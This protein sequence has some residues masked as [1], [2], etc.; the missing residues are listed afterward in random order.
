MRLDPEQRRAVDADG[1]VAVVAGAGTGKTHMLARR[2]LHHLCAG[3]LR[4]LEVVAVTF[5]RRAADELR[6]RIRS[7]LREALAQGEQ[8]FAPHAML[9]LE[10]A[11]IGTIHAL[12]QRICHA[13]PEAA[14]LPPDV[15]VLDDL[16]GRLWTAEA[17]DA[18]LERLRAAD[19]T[20]LP[21]SLLKRALQTLLAD[22]FRAEAALGKD[23]AQ[24]RA[25]LEA[26]RA[27][28]LADLRGDDWYAAVACLQAA[29]GPAEHPSEEARRAALASVGVLAE[30]NPEPAAEAQAWTVLAELRPHLG[31]SGEWRSLGRGDL[32]AVKAA[33]RSLRD[34]ARSAWQDA[35][36]PASWRFGALDETMIA[37]T[38]A[39]RQAFE[40]VRADLAARKRRAG[41]VDFGDL[42]V[43]A[44]RAVARPEVSAALRRRWRA[45]LV[46][47]YQDTSPAQ[48]R[49][50]E[51]LRGEAPV[52]VV[53]DEKQSIY[54]FRGADVGVFRS[55]RRALAERQGVDVALGTSYRSH[56]ALV[57]VLN[58]VFEVVLG[59]DAASL[60]ALRDQSS[61]PGPHV[62]FVRL[63]A[64][65]V[66]AAAAALAEAERLALEIRALLEA[67]PA[68]QV[69]DGAGGRRPLRAGDVAVLARSRASLEALEALAPSLGVPVLNA[70]GGDVLATR[71]ALDALALL[72]AV[73]DAS[74]A[75][76][77]L[78][79]LR[80][81]FVAASDVAIHALARRPGAGGAPWWVRLERSDDE[82]VRAGAALLAHLRA[83][84]ARGAGALEL[85]R[86][87]DARCGYA[88]VL[89]NL[90]NA[91]RRLA[92]WQGVLTLVAQL[93]AGGSDAFGLSRR[94][95]RLR[96]AQV[97]V[98]R[99]PL[100]SSDAVTLMTIHGA[101]G[102]EWPVVVVADLA[103]RTRAEAEEV[104]VD[105][106]L[107]VTLRWRDGAG[108]WAEPALYLLAEARGR[109]RAAAEDA[110]LS[111]VALT[112][113]REALLVSA[114]G[115]S[116]GLLDLLAP[117][118]AAA[119]I[120]PEVQLIDAE[121]A[122][123]LP[124]LPPVASEVDDGDRF[125]ARRC[126]GLDA[127]T[128]REV[129]DPT[130][131]FTVAA[132]PLP[133]ADPF[134][135]APLF[136]TAPSD[137]EASERANWR[138]ALMALTTLDEDGTWP[139]GVAA[140]AEA[141]V[142][143]PAL[144]DLLVP[145]PGPDGAGAEAIVRWPRAD[146]GVAL[147]A[148]EDLPEGTVNV[149]AWT[150]VPLDP[151]APEG[152]VM[153]LRAALPSDAAA[154]AGAAGDAGAAADA[155]AETEGRAA[156]RFDGSDG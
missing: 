27:N 30:P 72:A 120:E 25:E 97:K 14:G 126:D 79:T 83:L 84:H 96:A 101:K 125:W 127:A 7:A 132:P 94:L 95:Q 71:E 42:E 66:D 76:A 121:S 57:G 110:R 119:G 98:P 15:T 89:A 2:Y 17:L 39:L 103:R 56:A 82:R 81:P 152:A 58:R 102:L 133:P 92:D 32:A 28:A 5:T 148:S 16:D 4:P 60:Q 53:G 105:P 33:L 156:E 124:P 29:A 23:A 73:V 63:D 26:A 114:R 111:Y 11:P 41:V 151:L 1:S 51:L 61:L 116:G 75:P 149:G 91:A 142:P 104:V 115:A 13:F 65:G 49:L 52:T 109:A 131:G 8:P 67:D 24:L 59:A 69:D 90:P 18:A 145:V 106:D 141:G 134:A 113:A 3:G 137:P 78:A 10:A 21:F 112:R 48:A 136:A 46:D 6:A 68:L 138:D 153:A 87:A 117:G 9:E 128:A 144:A 47:E 74:D 155:G 19:V 143:A 80:G 107:G 62:R 99:P 40:R 45:I 35:R 130:A 140:L 108:G 43:H 147:L 37:R 70:G 146:G 123:P 20:A 36:G 88:A 54:G 44:V 38:A 139:A 150:Y 118:L 50:L 86:E 100:R 154:D 31:R 55:E 85:L 77:L 129:T 93:E 22:P 12:A 135:T 64:R 122:L 34:A